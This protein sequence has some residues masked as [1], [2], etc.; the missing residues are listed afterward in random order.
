MKKTVLF[1]VTCISLLATGCSG[2]QVSKVLNRAAKT[3]ENIP[4]TT[5]A[6][7]PTP[8]PTETQLKLGKKGKLDDWSIKVTKAQVKKSIKNG[9]YRYFDPGKGKRFVVISVSAKNN[10]KKAA[11]LFPFAGYV[12]KTISAVLIDKN[13]KKHKATR[14]LSYPKDMT[15][16]SVK[17]S[18]KLNGIV[19][20]Q[21]PA[22]TAKKLKNLSLRI[23]TS[24]NALVY[25]LR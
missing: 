5:A 18:K 10:S 25:E 1:L 14:L 12:D 17:P 21:V 24:K 22:K 13:K 6:P 7:T 9:K 8:G 2:K 15:S 11:Q 16:K 20:F 3:I 19:A 4:K 23:G